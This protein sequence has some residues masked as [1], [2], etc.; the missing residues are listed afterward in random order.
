[1]LGYNLEMRLQHISAYKS[2]FNQPT[3]ERN[4]QSCARAFYNSLTKCSDSELSK[5]NNKQNKSINSKS[6][7]KIVV[8]SRILKKVFIRR[9][10]SSN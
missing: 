3:V 6:Y 1:M 9:N 5:V 7:I 4:T 10:H 8:F 2:T